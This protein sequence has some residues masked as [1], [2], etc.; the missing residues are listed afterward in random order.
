MVVAIATTWIVGMEF[1]GSFERSFL[2]ETRKVKNT[3][4]TSGAAADGRYD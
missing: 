1:A 4:R 3:E 2:P